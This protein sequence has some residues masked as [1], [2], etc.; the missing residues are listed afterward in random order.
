MHYISTRGGISP[1]PFKDAVMMGLAT[2][3]GLLLPEVLPAVA[4]ETLKNWQSS[5]FQKLA[6]EIFRLFISD[7]ENDRLDELINLSYS[8]FSH[9]EITPLVKKGDLYIQEL[10]HGPT[11]AFKDVAL[12]FLGNVFAHML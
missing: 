2:D 9:P 6:A 3:G 1:I 7:I 5:S 11:L 12:Q 10:F 4:P 8:T